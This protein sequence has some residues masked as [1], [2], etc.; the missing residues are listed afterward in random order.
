VA[1]AARIS[2]IGFKPVRLEL[3]SSGLPQFRT[4]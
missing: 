1:A 2:N 3:N 4:V